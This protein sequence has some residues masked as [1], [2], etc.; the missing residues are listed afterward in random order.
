MN[1]MRFFRRA[2]AG[3]RSGEPAGRK[4]ALVEAANAHRD[5]RAWESAAQAYAQALAVEPADAG[6]WVQRGHALKE[7]GSLR[8]AADAYGKAAALAPADPDPW[9]HLAHLLKRLGDGQAAEAFATLLRLSNDPKTADEAERELWHLLRTGAG[10]RSAAAAWRMALIGRD[11]V[12]ARAAADACAAAFPSAPMEDVARAA[13]RLIVLGRPDLA[14]MK[15]AAALASPGLFG[16]PANSAG[17]GNFALVARWLGAADAFAAAFSPHAA[18]LAREEPDA[19]TAV[20]DTLAAALEPGALAAVLLSMLEAV[21]PLEDPTPALRLLRSI[22]GYCPGDAMR[23][24][25]ERIDR[26]RPELL[27]REEVARLV[28]NA[29]AQGLLPGGIDLSGS[30]ITTA[31]FERRAEPS[32]RI[33]GALR[34]GDARAFAAAADRFFAEGGGVERF[35]A[36]TRTHSVEIAAMA[37]SCERVPHLA[38]LGAR[39]RLLAALLLA[40]KAA[41]SALLAE[42]PPGQSDE[43]SLH[44]AALA[45]LGDFSAL[46]RAIARWC[47]EAGIE[48]VAFEGGGIAE[49]FAAFLRADVG[50]N[51]AR[52]ASAGKIA[53]IC[54]VFNPD[55]DLL[56]LAM[57]SVAAQ[58]YADLDV[59]VIDDGSDAVAPEAIGEAALVD[60]RFRFHRMARNAGPYE[61]RNWAL[62]NSD[63]PFVAINDGDDFSHPQRFAVQVAALTRFPD[64]RL[65]TTAHIRIDREGYPQLEGNLDIRGDAPGT[66]LYRRAAFEECGPFAS[67]RSR[68]DVE[69]RERVRALAGSDAIRHD[70]CPLLYCLASPASLSNTVESGRG[71]WLELLRDTFMRRAEIL[72][73]SLDGCEPP[74]L[75]VP[76]PLRPSG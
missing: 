48:P 45:R 59:L 57:R 12:D 6:I 68:G 72:A 5:A 30:G 39:D 70:P 19:L 4:A 20:A 47:A 21:I 28:G 40:D 37:V 41:L 33:L 51:V 61:C 74:P 56:R 8:E 71:A 44:L 76:F 11:G 63:A 67:V 60:G 22:S 69:F 43:D 15:L 27:A 55:L 9:L 13:R 2:R 29:S 16:E 35:A 7:H 38:R 65:S 17:L 46:N 26:E 49:T 66:S 75:A 42:M 14:R 62:R 50:A 36:L 23:H 25:L 53:V 24:A 58:T 54:S 3:P 64:A 73:L 1:L 52:A 18:R 32:A 34:S 10:G 31:D